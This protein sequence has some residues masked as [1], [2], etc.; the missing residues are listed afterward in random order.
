MEKDNGGEIRSLYPRNPHCN[1]VRIIALPDA[2][3]LKEGRVRAIGR[4]RSRRQVRAGK[5]QEDNH[6]RVKTGRGIPVAYLA[7]FWSAIN[8]VIFKLKTESMADKKTR[9]RMRG[10][11]IGE[12]E[13]SYWRGLLADTHPYITAALALEPCDRL[14]VMRAGPPPLY[15]IN[16]S[17]GARSYPPAWDIIGC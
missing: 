17:W 14:P 3:K 9:R 10:G 1:A 7:G 15:F 5:G 16:L 4:L 12:A 11:P 8:I 2:I 13:A 6:R